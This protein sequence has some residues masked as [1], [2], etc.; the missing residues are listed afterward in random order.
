MAAAI[1]SIAGMLIARWFLEP[2]MMG[3]C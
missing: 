2:N 3:A 1:G